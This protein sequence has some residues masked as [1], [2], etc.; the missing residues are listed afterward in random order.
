MV[1]SKRM[2]SIEAMVASNVVVPVVPPVTRLPGDTRRSPMRPETGARSSVNS[3]SSVGLAHGRLLRRDVGLGHA[4]GLRALIEGLLR[5]G[6]AAHQALPALQI[7]LGVGE[8][9]AG[10]GEVRLRLRQRGLEW[11]AVD[12]EEQ[13]ALLYQLPVL[14]VYR[15]E[16]AGH[17]SPHLDGIDRDEAADVLVAIG[18]QPLN[19]LGDSHLRG[20]GWSSLGARLARVTAGEQQQEQR[21][22][23]P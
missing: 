13:V 3:R 20:G 9:G 14:E 18:D 10:L 16:I 22:R 17:A 21:G 11:P 8:I 6:T 23:D 2:G 15:V 12:G 1:N 4:L 7:G 5:D 19:R